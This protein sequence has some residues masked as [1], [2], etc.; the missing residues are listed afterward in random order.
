M[1]RYLAA[2]LAVAA[3]VVPAAQADRYTHSHATPPTENA[4]SQWSLISQ[5]AISVGR[6]PASSEVLHG[7]VHAA[8]YDAVVAIK[9]EYEPFAVSVRSPRSAS[10]DAAVAAAARGLLVVRV[11]AQAAA[12][13]TAY[14]AFLAGLPDGPAKTKGLRLGRA[15]AGAYL[16]LR[17]DDGYDN[18]VPW[19]Q[20]PVGPGV[21]E[22]IP[23]TSQPVDAK[24]QQ[25]RPL[26]F[27]DAD[28]FAP[29]PPYALSSPEYTADF[30]EV[31]ALGRADSAV[32]T[33]EQT[34]VA[35]FWTEHPM[36]QYNRVLRALAL[37]KRLNVVETAR[38]MA[39]VHVSAA[40]T[41]VGCWWTKHRDNFWRPVQAIQ[42]ADRD[43]NPDTVADATW[44][45]LV[46][47]NHPEYP[48]GHMCIT[49]AQTF[50][51]E[52]FFGT[53]RIPLTVENR[54]LVPNVVLTRHFDRLRDIRAEVTLARIY[55]G[56]HFRKAMIASEK[57]GK[58]TA[59]YVTRRFFDKD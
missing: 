51:L 35:R 44:N 28:R 23:P 57:L 56:L 2:V 6:P 48:S 46:L 5:N 8:I 9:R 34:L 59:R 53:D 15:I 24:L 49:A 3:M 43:G 7:L 16:A 4:V 25:V 14:T 36:I 30:N 1:F 33:A 18:V 31:K 21:F 10:V 19:V 58:D 13:E 12:V 42:R 38:M 37:E 41:Q 11:P 27:D 50:A 45:H 22:P 32:R 26:S 55:G 39:M 20:P 52:A 54:A 17:A 47:G 40:D 29:S